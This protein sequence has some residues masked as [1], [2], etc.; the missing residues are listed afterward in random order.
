[1]QALHASFSE[2]QV[3]C[4]KCT[5]IQH[6]QGQIRTREKINNLKFLE[7]FQC[8]HISFPSWRKSSELVPGFSI[9]A[10]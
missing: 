5:E 2:L 7:W 3:N 9:L 6:V 4:R 8:I 10:Q 1:M